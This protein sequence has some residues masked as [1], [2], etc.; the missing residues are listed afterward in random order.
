M[1]DKALSRSKSSAACYNREAEEMTTNQ[2][3][4]VHRWYNYETQV[5]HRRRHSRPNKRE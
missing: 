3:I 4:P 2:K 5:V 1:G